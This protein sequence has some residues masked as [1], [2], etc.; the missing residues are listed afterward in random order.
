ICRIRPSYY[1][2]GDT[3][4]VAANHVETFGAPEKAKQDSVYTEGSEPVVIIPKSDENIRSE[5]CPR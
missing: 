2:A 4:H 5:P 1:I 3:I